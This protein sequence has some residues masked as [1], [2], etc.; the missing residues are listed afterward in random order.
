MHHIITYPPYQLLFHRVGYH[1]FVRQD[2]LHQLGTQP[3]HEQLRTAGKI[4]TVPN[5]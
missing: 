2:S 1:F 3:E 4:D 5:L